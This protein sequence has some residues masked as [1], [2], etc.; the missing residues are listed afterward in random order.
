MPTPQYQHS[1]YVLLDKVHQREQWLTK[2]RLYA[3]EL[4]ERITATVSGDGRSRDASVLQ[5]Q[6]ESLKAEIAEVS[7]DGAVGMIDGYNTGGRW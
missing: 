2:A 6:L 5:Q 7:G 3:Q 4:I 1:D